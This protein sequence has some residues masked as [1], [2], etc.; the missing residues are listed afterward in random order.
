MPTMRLFI[1]IFLL[2]TASANA[3]TPSYITFPSDVDWVTKESANFTLLYRRDQNRLADRTL[4]AAEKAYRILKPIF[5]ETPPKTWIVLADFHDSLNGYAINFP[6]PH[7]VIFAAP[8]EPSSQLAALDDWLDSVILHEYVHVLHL[9]PAHG[10]WSVAQT[11][12]G[13]WVLPNGLLP[14]HLH[15]GLATFLETELT[16]GGR[17]RGASFSMLRRMA[18]QKKVWGKDFVPLDLLEGSNRWPQG[19][20]PYFFGYLAYQELWRRKGRSGL[21][22]FVQATSRRFPYFFSGA[23]EEIYGLNYPSLWKEVFAKNEALALEE[24]SAISK[25]PLAKLKYITDSKHHKWALQISSDRSQI[26]YRSANPDSGATIEIRSTSTGESTR[27]ISIE[28]GHQE[29]LCWFD[30]N[31]TAFLAFAE[32]SNEFGYSKNRLQFYNTLTAEKFSPL[33]SSQPLSNV[34]TLS[35]STNS[36]IT[37]QEEK[38]IGHLREWNLSEDLHSLTLNREWKLPEATWVSS[39]RA[40]SPPLFALRKSRFT[41]FM[42]WGVGEPKKLLELKGNFYHLGERLSSGEWPVVADTSG[43]EEVWALDFS[44]NSSRKLVAVLGGVNSFAHSGDRWWISSYEHG[45]YDIAQTET[46]SGITRETV[47]EV[48]EPQTSAGNLVESFPTKEY[49]PWSSLRPRA[50]IPSILIVPNGAQVSA[51]I[52]G[53]DVSQKH[54]YNF[55]GGYDTRG[56]PYMYAD[57]SYRFKRSTQ[58]N[59]SANYSPSYL[60]SSKAFLHQWGASVGISTSLGTDLPR[61]SGSAQF[62]RVEKSSY[63][64][65]NQSIG[66]GVSLSQTFF[67]RTAPR[68]I[69]PRFATLASI[70]HS[71]FFKALGSTDNYYVTMAGVDQYLPNPFLNRHGMKLALK[72]GITEGTALYNSFFQGGGELM[73]SPGR[74]LFLNRG[75]LPGLFSSQRILCFNL[76]YF[77]PIVE[78]ERGLSTWPFFLKRIDGALVFDATGVGKFRTVYTSAGVELKSYW[79]TFFYFP[80]LVR[81]G[82]YHGFGTFGEA[83]YGTMA[84]E[85]SL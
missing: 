14:S 62:R 50:W 65:A 34:Q 70:S 77:F 84:I 73:F 44:K 26:A 30:K 1:G 40:S 68:A 42:E 2:F 24:I 37:Y 36:L 78:V 11:I 5:E 54:L 66:L 67:A 64:P 16:Q 52:P 29:S 58:L 15:E 56:S 18:V 7:F 4:A 10:F 19:Q 55:F 28:G 61:L 60:I 83:F 9:F 41:T 31:K 13:S 79:K 71:Q 45:G 81:F 38:G 8:P 57:Y 74:G 20:S 80:T 39:I 22:S 33:H 27:S 49:S 46:I 43:R 25:E 47:Q 59:W 17:G 51:W 23:I 85:A 35:C 53:F 48:S 75:F 3:E 72:G 6:F 63:G 21:H 12:F 32:T 76:D 69:A 82:A